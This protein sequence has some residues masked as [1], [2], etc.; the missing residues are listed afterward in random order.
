MECDVTMSREPERTALSV[1]VDPERDHIT[2]PLDAPLELLEYGDYECPYCGLA[3]PVVAAVRQTLG[4][5]LR[6][7]FRHFPIVS[8]HPHALHA[9]EAAEAAGAQ[10][11]FWE[12]HNE[13]FDRQ[14][15]LEDEMLVRY[16]IGLG[17]ER[18]RFVGD[19]VSQRFL[20]RVREDLVS[21]SES[22]V[23]GTPTFFANGLRYDGV[24]DAELL[25]EALE[26]TASV[27]R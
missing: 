19:L 13:L 21:G 5:R 6:F 7:S 22:G 15:A 20:P 4:R 9:A 1:P 14:D 27:R 26:R 8:A 2:G 10:G 3:Q 18:K 16:A 12:M 24:A 11:A 25:V 17:L 23:V